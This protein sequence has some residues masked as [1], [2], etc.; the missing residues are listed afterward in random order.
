MLVCMFPVSGIM[1]FHI[2][3]K[4][5]GICFEGDW[6]TGMSKLPFTHHYSLLINKGGQGAKIL[7]GRILALSWCFLCLL[8]VKPPTKARHFSHSL[9]WQLKI[10]HNVWK[11]DVAMHNSIQ[12]SSFMPQNATRLFIWK[13]LQIWT[14]CQMSRVACVCDQWATVLCF[15]LLSKHVA[16]ITCNFVQHYIHKK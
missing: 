3:L 4:E 13:A 11:K 6:S 12:C 7:T 14:Y 9:H 16:Y 8:S 10:R 1:K 5:Y 15:H 2:L